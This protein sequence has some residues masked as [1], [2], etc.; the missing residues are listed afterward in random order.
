[1]PP[2]RD[3]F[4]VG[5]LGVGYALTTDTTFELSYLFRRNASTLDLATFD[6]DVLSLSASS[7]F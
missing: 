1:V 2:R 4:W 3:D 6:D 7:R 5:D